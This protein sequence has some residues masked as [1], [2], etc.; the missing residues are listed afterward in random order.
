MI[1]YEQVRSPLPEDI[2]AYLSA[3]RALGVGLGI[4][5]DVENGDYAQTDALFTVNGIPL[6]EGLASTYYTV[7]VA[8]EATPEEIKAQHDA[9]AMYY[10]AEQKKLEDLQ[11]RMTAGDPS[12]FEEFQ[13]QSIH[14]AMDR[15]ALYGEGTGNIR[16]IATP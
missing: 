13:R 16:G 1:I 12:A 7:T 5:L 10:A 6:E 15:A 9:F 11:A 3:L 8:R 2:L 4:E 14:E